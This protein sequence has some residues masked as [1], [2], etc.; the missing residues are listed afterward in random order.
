MKDNLYFIAILAPDDVSA[1]ITAFKQD[2]ADNFNSSKALRSMP[3]ITLVPPF[4]LSAQQH[5]DLNRWFLNT[6]VSVSPFTIN[7]NG[8]G[9]FN[10]SNNPVIYVKPE[11]VG[12][13]RILQKE[14]V[15]SFKINYPEIK[16]AQSFNPHMT[17][18]YRDLSC[19]NYEKAWPLYE[20]KTYK[21]TFKTTEVWLL[22]HNGKSWVQITSK[23]L[24]DTH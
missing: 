7:L 6:P 12:E 14:L 13:L 19:E 9:S 3:H 10:N 17:I 11:E 24:T 15:S 23:A 5:E 18:A 20:D 4:K 1:E 2:I 8:F 16:A 22:Q 21:A